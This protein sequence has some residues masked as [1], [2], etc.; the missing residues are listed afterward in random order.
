MAEVKGNGVTAV[1]AD[2][3]LN[4]LNVD[5]QGFDAMDR[6]LLAIVDRFGGGPVGLDALA[7]SI[8]EERAR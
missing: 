5:K 3:A 8:S 4:L 6:V 1:L 2:E 7:A